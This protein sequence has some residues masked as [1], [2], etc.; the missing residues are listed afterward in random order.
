MKLPF[1]LNDALGGIVSIGIPLVFK[2]MVNQ[3]IEDKN[4]DV[5]LAVKYIQ[6]NRSLL[7]L[8]KE[9]SPDDFETVVQRCSHYIKNADWLTSDWLINATRD[10]H[11]GLASLFMGWDEA[12]A[13][14]DVQTETFRQE[15]TKETNPEAQQVIQP[16]PQPIATPTAKTPDIWQLPKKETK[17]PVPDQ[18]ENTAPPAKPKDFPALV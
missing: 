11:P 17:I 13:W 9:Y 12:R 2:G 7:E 10:E 1:K 6:E 4:L 8:F 18:A 15:F 3:F 5:K 16:P 14:L